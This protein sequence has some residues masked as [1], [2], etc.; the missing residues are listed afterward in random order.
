MV[1]RL[2]SCQIVG[3][4][5]LRPNPEDYIPPVSDFHWAQTTFTDAAI[6]CEHYQSWYF[7]QTSEHSVCFLF[8]LMRS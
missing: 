3:V 8:S 6:G 5:F 2:T 7:S 4:F 1:G